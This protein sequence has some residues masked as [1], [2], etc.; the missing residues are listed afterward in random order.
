[1]EP[2][3][4]HSEGAGAGDAGGG[5]ESHYLAIVSVCPTTTDQSTLS[6]KYLNLHVKGDICEPIGIQESQADIHLLQVSVQ[7]GEG[8]TGYNPHTLEM[9]TEDY[10]FKASLGYREMPFQKSTV[11]VW[12][13][14]SVGRALA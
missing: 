3:T 4:Q 2:G 1:M 13:C 8:V 10:E 6:L 14:G 11:M 7:A 5:D 12:G 9:E